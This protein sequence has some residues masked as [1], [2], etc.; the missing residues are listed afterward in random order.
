MF[1]V[2]NFLILP[3]W[4]YTLVCKT[5]DIFLV[6]ILKS[7]INRIILYC[8]WL[9]FIFWKRELI[10][11]AKIFIKH[12]NY[13]SYL[14]GELPKFWC[15]FNTCLSCSWGKFP[16]SPWR[17]YQNHTTGFFKWHKYIYTD[18]QHIHMHTH[19]PLSGKC[20]TPSCRINDAADHGA[21]YEYVIIL[22]CI[23]EA[24]LRQ[25]KKKSQETLIV[26]RWS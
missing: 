17:V 9:V 24:V 18:T 25:K 19:F 23:R 14:Y 6:L 12:N 2:S 16:V 10:V 7:I 3:K 1:S 11:C 4:I 5:K 26:K 21:W 8:L 22:T 20:L 13:F 15:T